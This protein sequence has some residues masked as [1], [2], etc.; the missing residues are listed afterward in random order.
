MI[1]GVFPPRASGHLPDE[2]A[3]HVRGW[4][5][6][7]VADGAAGCCHAGE[8]CADRAATD[9]NAAGCVQTSRQTLAMIHK[10]LWV[11]VTGGCLDRCH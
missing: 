2:T 9:V 6:G 10:W 8:D 7:R 1:F 3:L 4:L 11:A 5:V